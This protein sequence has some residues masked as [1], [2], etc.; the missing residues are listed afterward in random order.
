MEQLGRC[1]NLCENLSQCDLTGV[2]LTDEPCRALFSTLK[3]NAVLTTLSISENSIGDEGAVAIAEALRGNKVLT[4]L[5]L[6]DNGIGDEGATALASALGGAAMVERA[7][8]PEPTMSLPVLRSAGQTPFTAASSACG[9]SGRA[10]K[11]TA[12]AA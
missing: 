7:A 10:A 8:A 6:D 11:R 2:G 5:W 1:L 4:E 12:C 9:S 3:F